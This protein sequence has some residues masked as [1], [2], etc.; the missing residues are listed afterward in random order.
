MMAALGL[1]KKEI[2]QLF[3]IEGGFM[4]LIGSLLGALGGYA[5]YCLFRKSRI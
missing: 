2:L 1:E 3:L 4:G 5:N